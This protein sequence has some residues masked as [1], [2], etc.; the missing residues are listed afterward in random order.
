MRSNLLHIYQV[1]LHLPSGS[2]STPSKQPARRALHHC[3]LL[4]ECLLGLLFNPEDGGNTFLQNIS[5]LLQSCTVSDPWRLYWSEFSVLHVSLGPEYSSDS[6][7][8]TPSKYSPGTV[9]PRNREQIPQEYNPPG[10]H[11]LGNHYHH[12]RGICYVCSHLENQWN[13]RIGQH[14]NMRF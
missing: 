11:L 1:L 6:Q 14:H 9:H 3:L 7:N 13:T 5:E 8:M 10:H 2:T 12:R 4:A